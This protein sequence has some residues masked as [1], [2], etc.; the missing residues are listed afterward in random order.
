M[1]KGLDS[2]IRLHE[3]KLDEKRRKVADLERLAQR[4]LDQLAGLDTEIRA[5]QKIAAKD[6]MVTGSY[7]SYASGV[8]ARRERLLR[9]LKDVEAEMGRALD[10]VAAAFREFKKFDLIRSRNR[11]RA[12]LREARIQ[13]GELDEAG[14]GVFR[15]SHSR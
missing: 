14:L 15:R 2:L 3:W 11:E 10:E 4:L 9:S 5:E 12:E 8:I 13:Q 1:M 6:P 7:G